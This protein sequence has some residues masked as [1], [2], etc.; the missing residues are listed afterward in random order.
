MGSRALTS[1][2]SSTSSAS[3]TRDGQGFYYSRYD[4]PKAG[5]ALTA[6]N[7]YQKLYYHRLGT[8]QSEDVLVYHRPDEK[9]WGFNGEV[10]EDG[11]YLIINIR[12]GTD[13][14]N[15]IYYKEIKSANP[16]VALAYGPW[17]RLR[18]SPEEGWALV[19]GERT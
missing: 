1:W 9:E 2:T 18:I 7:Y 4:E 17:F 12:Q 16:E 10:S 19:E 3:W 8:P 13:T 5:E 15:R 14:R 6:Q 11:R